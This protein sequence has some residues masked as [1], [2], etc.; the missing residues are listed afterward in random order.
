MNPFEK[1]KPISKDPMMNVR[2]YLTSTYK[3]KKAFAQPKAK[4]LFEK[5][6]PISEKVKCA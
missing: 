4:S 1:T 5:T 2:L 3:N 6:K